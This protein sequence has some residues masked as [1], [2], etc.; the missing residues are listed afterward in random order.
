MKNTYYI[1]T[2]I[3]YASG[4]LHIGHIYTTVITDCITRFK[5]LQGIDTFF[6]TGTDEHGLKI[7]QIAENNGKN[8]KEFVDEK[9]EKI[10]SLWKLFDIR[11]DKFIRTTDSYH[12]ETVQKIFKTLYDNGDIYKGV[13]ED[14]YCIPCESFFTTTQLKDGKCPDCGRDVILQKEDAYFFRINKYADKLLE[15]IENNPDFIQPISRKNEMI[16]NF[17]KPGL[18][19]LCISRTSFKWG[20]P[21]SFDSKHVVYVWIDALSNYI[22]A[23]GYKNDCENLMDK[24]WPADLHI[25]GKEIVRFHVIYWP[26]LL[27]ALNLPL[28]KKIFGHGW[29]VING[30]KISK[31][32]GATINPITLSKHFP[33]DAI[34]Y[35]L[36]REIPFGSDGSFDNKLF[37]SRINSDLSNLLGNLVS[38][39]IAMIQ[40]YFDGIIPNQDK[41]EDIDKPLITSV[42][43]LKNSVCKNMDDLKISSAIEE[44]FNVINNSNKYIDET[45]PWIICNEPDKKD[46]LGTVLYNLCE[47]IRVCSILLSPFIPDTSEKIK[48]K[49]NYEIYDFNSL[50][51]FNGTKSGTIVNKGDN[52]FPRI[53][54]EKK[55][56]ELENENL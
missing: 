5:K 32:Q 55:L 20:V 22:S 50:D 4:D 54:I 43:N 25:V 27:L 41:I 3:Y 28:P 36:L 7:Q 48:N 33:I 38:R 45:K 40:K 11:Y 1:T 2:P 49:L 31:S 29:L 37:I 42:V 44:I 30:S 12:I 18:K 56:I 51:K 13:Y 15:H 47:S 39:T 14:Y 34:K 52:L 6:L 8:P 21:V 23:L 16:N 24:L 35:F 26:I 46:R 9:V 53:D 10:K 19:D 17:I